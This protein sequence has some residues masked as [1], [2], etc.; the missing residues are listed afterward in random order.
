MMCADLM[1]SIG[2]FLSMAL[3]FYY[4]TYAVK[5]PLLLSAHM[6]ISAIAQLIGASLSPFISKLIKEPKHRYI[7]FFSFEVVIL[8][9]ASF[10]SSNPY[11]VLAMFAF[12]YVV[13]GAAMPTNSVLYAN[14]AVYTRWKSG[15]NIGS[16]VMGMTEIP[17]KL[18]LLF[19]GILIAFALSALGIVAG[20]EVSAQT[21]NE[22]SKL[23]ILAPG[24]GAF[25]AG[26]IVKFFYALD[27]NK[28]N[29]LRQ[30]I[31]D[32]DNTPTPFY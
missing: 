12:F 26:M 13:I 30:E 10:F 21:A 18:G 19:R 27:E 5:M 24:I 1:I 29:E 3:A 22:I 7:L 15:N 11:I 6:T 17:I 9:T 32:R 20:Q 8:V 2:N 28:V 31:W 23:F 16:F 14:T 4:Y 25:L